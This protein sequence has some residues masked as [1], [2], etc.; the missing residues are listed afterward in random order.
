MWAKFLYYADAIQWIDATTADVCPG[1]IALLVHLL[2]HSDTILF[3]SLRYLRWTET[4]ADTNDLTYML[5]PSLHELQLHVYDFYDTPYTSFAFSEW[6]ARIFHII[7][8]LCPNLR[9]FSVVGM[10]PVILNTSVL[11]YFGSMHQVTITQQAFGCKYI[12][13]RT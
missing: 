3:R 7:A 1:T 2:P 11:T 9:L 5:S 12:Q 8:H 4:F 6:V 10:D 13:Y